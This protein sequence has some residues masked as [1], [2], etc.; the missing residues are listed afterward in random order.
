MPAF[1]SSTTNPLGD[2]T[3]PTQGGVPTGTGAS[4]QAQQAAE[5]EVFSEQEMSVLQTNVDKFKT[6]S[7]AERHK[8]LVS[9]VLPQLRSFN[10]H[11]NQEKWDLRKAVSIPGHTMSISTVHRKSSRSK[12][13]FKTTAVVTI[14]RLTWDSTRRL[15]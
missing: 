3:A 11:L 4:Q 7:K 1:N 14:L 13:G 6:S 9:E 12:S 10:L 5:K 2:S 8:L 15:R